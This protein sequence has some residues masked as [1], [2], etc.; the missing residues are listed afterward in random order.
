MSSITVPSAIEDW[1]QQNIS[2]KY[3]YKRFIFTSTDER[4]QT[5]KTATLLN[6]FYHKMK[7]KN[8]FWIYEKRRNI[9]RRGKIWK[10]L[11]HL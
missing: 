3:N 1:Q 2:N 5:L 6:R 11:I 8:L 9:S 4:R 7:R 10:F